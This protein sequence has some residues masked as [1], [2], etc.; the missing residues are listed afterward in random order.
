MTKSN[1]RFGCAGKLAHPT[2]VAARTHLQ[3]LPAAGAAA[4]TTLTTYRCRHCL[5][6]H[7]GHLRTG[8]S[9]P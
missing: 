7:V 4:T 3:R 2:P 5:A 1:K 9:R 6:W 8:Y